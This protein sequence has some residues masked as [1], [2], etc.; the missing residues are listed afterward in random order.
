MARRSSGGI[1]DA[2]IRDDGAA[3]SRVSPTV[4]SRGACFSRLA[5][6]ERASVTHTR[7]AILARFG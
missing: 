2:C 1:L 3:D 4:A 5:S 6:E 7:A